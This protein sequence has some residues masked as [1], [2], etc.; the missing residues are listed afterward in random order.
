MTDIQIYLNKL[1]EDPYNQSNTFTLAREYEKAG[2]TAAALSYYL[3][4]A[5]YGENLDLIYE[6]LIRA[7]KCLGAQGRRKVSEKGKS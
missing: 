6:A 4:V 7:G 1:I 5:E 2:H 3:R